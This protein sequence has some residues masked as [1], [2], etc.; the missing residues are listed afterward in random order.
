VHF[1][2]WS[3]RSSVLVFFRLYG[4]QSTHVSSPALRSFVYKLLS[5]SSTG[6]SRYKLG[7]IQIMHL[8]T[9]EAW[10]ASFRQYRSCFWYVHPPT[11]LYPGS[12]DIPHVLHLDVLAFSI[13]LFTAKRSGVNRHPSVPSLLDTILRDAT[14]Y[15]LLMFFSQVLSQ[16]FLLVNMVGGYDT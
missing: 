2:S 15:F 14:G 8:R 3:Q 9:V 1:P 5:V 12:S 16:V 6:V 10:G 4:L 11:Y 7:R 13:I